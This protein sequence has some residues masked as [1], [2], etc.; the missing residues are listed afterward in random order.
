MRVVIYGAGAV[1]SLLAALLARAKEEVVVVGS[2][3]HVQAIREHGL[4]VEGSVEGSWP[5]TAVE[6]LDPRSE[7]DLLLLTVKSFDLERAVD[8][9]APLLERPL[10]VLLPQNGLGIERIVEGALRRNLPQ[11]TVLPPLVRAVNTLPATLVG[12][13]RVRFAGSGELRLAEPSG[14]RP[15]DQ[16]IRAFHAL[17]E[18]AG[19]AVRYVPDLEP[20]L[21]LKA[22]VNA[23]IN[24][25][26]AAFSVPNGSLASA[27]YRSLA[28]ALVEEGVEAARAAGHPLDLAAARE[29]MWRTVHATAE[30]R[31]SMLQ[32]IDRGRPTE[33]AVISEALLAAGRS[34]GLPMLETARI[35][36]RVRA[37]VPAAEQRS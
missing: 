21:W 31:S 6:R 30:N 37:R 11:P 15:L 20:A 24:P 5:L 18:R 4:H 2:P 10:P 26:T 8:A 32:D 36:A 27:P 33:I 12:P 23:T 9:L 17:F 14:T 7:L 3:A 35:V 1:G 25:I 13:G 29:E 28:E 22:V 34:H 19:I 16:A